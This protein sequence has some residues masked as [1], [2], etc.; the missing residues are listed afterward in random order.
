MDAYTFLQVVWFVLISILWLGYF[1]L[2]GFDFGVGML[3]RAVTRDDDERRAVLHSIG[4]IWDGNEVWLLV[5]GGATFAAFPQW[6]ATLFSGF[7]L[8]LFLILLGLIVRNVSFEFWG[9]G[10]SDAWRRRWEWAMIVGSAVPAL[11]WGVGWANIVHGVPIDAGHE[12]TGTLFDLLNPYALL[13]GLATLSIF[14]AHGAI[15]L[16][17]K[18]EGAIGERAKAIAGRVAP[19]AAAVGIAFLVWTVLDHPGGGVDI[20]S[21]ILA[22]LSAA[23]LIA[24]AYLA[25]RD[26]L[27]SF[28]ATSAAILTF[29]CA[30]FVDLFPHTMVSST[31]TAFS[32]TLNQSASSSYTL[33]VMT[34]VAVLLVPVVLAYQAWTYW[35]F[36]QRVSARDFKEIDRR[37]PLDV[38]AGA[39]ADVER[40]RGSGGK[41][42][43]GSSGEPA[44]AAGS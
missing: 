34:V 13:G 28:V 33:T 44:G 17:L 16:E 41:E 8:A 12:Y 32:M 29:F 24:A 10:E 23:A 6:Y 18:T 9:K 1:L 14:L 4:P 20:A 37:S 2:E 38:L 5:A 21:A 19:I 25:G 22:A 31:D 7:Y 26:P 43:E 35:V 15:F 36:R 27:R 40:A 42:E 30:L 39:K 3:F 11:L